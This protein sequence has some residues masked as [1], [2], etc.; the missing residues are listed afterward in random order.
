MAMSNH[1][2]Y[3]RVLVIDDDPLLRWSIR[4]T[5]AGVGHAVMTAKDANSAWCELRETPAVYDVVL[6]GH[7]LLDTASFDLLAYMQRHLRS[8]VAVF[9]PADINDDDILAARK[10]GVVGVL[11]KPFDMTALHRAVCDAAGI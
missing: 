11:K 6:L 3:Q 2:F 1:S 9:M 7:P 4:E 5:V 8:T 10:L